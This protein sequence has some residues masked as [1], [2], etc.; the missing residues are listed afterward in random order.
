MA[1]L[2]LLLTAGY[3]VPLRAQTLAGDAAQAVG[4]P[5]FSRGTSGWTLGDAAGLSALAVVAL[6]A[7]EV[8]GVK[9]ALQLDVHTAKGI[10]P[11]DIQLARDLA[12][13]IANGEAVRFSFWGK[14]DKEAK[15]GAGV[16]VGSGD[17][18]KLGFDT[19]TLSPNWKHYEIIGRA[20]RDFT[21]GQTHVIMHLGA[22]DARITLAGVR[23][24]DPDHPLPPAVA[25]DDAPFKPQSLVPNADF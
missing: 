24:E 19:V 10:N 6:Q 11:W 17:Y 8:V 15:V 3:S 14:A 25:T 7:G 20:A 21:P 4:N 12:V 2:A 1:S 13:G 16:E 22:Q 9:R 5:R 18:Q 23:V